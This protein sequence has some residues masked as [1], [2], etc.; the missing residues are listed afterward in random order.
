MKLLWLYILD[1]CSDLGIWIVDK[2]LAEFC[3]GGKRRVKIDWEKA[4]SYFDDKIDILNNGEKWYIKKFLKYQGTNFRNFPEYH[5][6]RI[7]VYKRDKYTCRICGQIGGKLN[8]HHK[9]SYIKYPEIALDINNGITLCKECHK[10]VH[11]SKINLEIY[12][13]EEI[14]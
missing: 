11:K 5:K 7:N 8:A 4:I 12:N 9:K 1:D 10:K 14:Y 3:I 6:W 2:E 13:E